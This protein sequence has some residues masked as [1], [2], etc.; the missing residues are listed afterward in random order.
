MN[1]QTKSFQSIISKRSQASQT[2]ILLKV[3]SFY[4]IHFALCLACSS[5]K[6]QFKYLPHNL[7]EK[8]SW[9]TPV[10]H[11][12][13]PVQF[14]FKILLFIVPLCYMFSWV[15][16]MA[17]LWHRL[18][19]STHS[20]NCCVSFK[21]EYGI[22][23]LADA[24]YL[25][26]ETVWM[27]HMRPCSDIRLLV[28]WGLHPPRAAAQITATLSLWLD[29]LKISLRESC[30]ILNYVE[31]ALL[32]HHNMHF[33]RSSR[34]CIFSLKSFGLPIAIF[35]RTFISV[36]ICWPHNNLIRKL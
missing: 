32:K 16:F 5:F 12:T 3:F 26:L 17:V 6:I 20:I 24:Q 10:N 22:Q 15:C 11:L 19:Q 35:S 13:P 23:S 25:L 21:A 1:R 29:D 18:R 27:E 33:T 2:V 31:Q 36:I 7:A 28:G 4:D 9:I 34:T 14:N 8:A 30:G